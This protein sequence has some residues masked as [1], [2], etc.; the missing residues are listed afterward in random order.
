MTPLIEL[1]NPAGLWWLAVVPL[2]LVPYWLRQRPRRRLVPALFL[3]FGAEPARR[4]RLGGRLRLRPLIVLQ[5][6][7][8]LAVVGALCRPAWRAT[9]VRA[10]L[11]LD[12]SASLRAVDSGQTRFAAAVGAARDEVSRHPATS[13]DL[14]LLSPTPHEVGTNLSASATLARLNELDV[15]ECPHPDES[16]LRS[17]LERL[18]RDRYAGVFVFTD[19]LGSSNPG[20]S[21][22]TVGSPQPNLAIT[23]LTVVPAPVASS[24]ASLNVVVD[25]LSPRPAS[26]PIRVLGERGEQLR[27]GTLEVGAHGSAAF[28]TEAPAAGVLTAHIDGKDALAFDDE[29]SIRMGL[30]G[31]RSLLLVANDAGGLDALQKLLGF[32]LEV[33]PPA[34]YRPELARGRDLVI[35]HLSA[36]SEPAM[37]SAL[38]LLP[39]PTPF[40]PGAV[41]KADAPS[42]AFPLQTHPIARYLNPAALRP[43][44]LLTLAGLP[45]W[46]PLAVADG[47]PVILEHLGSPRAIVS[48]MDLLPYLG[49]RNRPVSILTLNVLSWLLRGAADGGRGSERQCVPIGRAESDLEHPRS[50]PLS[51]NGS[52]AAELRERLHPLWSALT[53]AAL[54]LL[55]LEAWFHRG[56][57]RV[58]WA[59]RALTAALII[60]AWLDPMR[61]IAGVAPPPLALLDVSKSLLEETRTRAIASLGL[62]PTAPILAFAGRPVATTVDRLASAVAKAEV[63]ATDLEAA[64]LNAVDDAPQGGAILLVSDGWETHGDA[65]KA[66]EAIQKRGLRVFPIAAAQSLGN[67]VA[68]TSLSLPAQSASGSAARAEVL[69]R[70]DNRDAVRARITVRQ[71]SK[72]LVREVTRIPPGDSAFGRT[73]LLGGEGLSEF[74]A[75]LQPLDPATDA[76]RSNDVAKA[77]VAIGGGKRVLLLGH[78]RRDNREL[79]HTL[80]A[81]G[82]RVTSVGRADGEAAPEPSRFAAVVLNDLPLSDLPPG[83]ADQLRES[84]RGGG[85][86]AMV[87][88]PRSFGLGGYRGSAVEEALPVRMKERQREEPGNV[89]ALVIDKS[90]SMREESRILYAREAARQLVDHLKDHDRI[91]VIGFDRE[92]F[93]IVPLAEVGEIR[94]EFDERIDRL[95]PSGG[96][97]L[98]PALVEARRQL[99]G[100]EA[101][102]RHVIVLSDGLSE[103]AQSSAQRRQYYD[104]ALALAEQGVTIST[105]ALGREADA[106]FLEHLASFGRGVFHETAEASSLP[107]LVLGEFET[108]GREKTLA[109]REFRPLPAPDSPLVGDLA[110]AE[111]R[112]PLVLGLVETELKPQARLDV[113]VSGSDAPLIASWEFGRGRAVAVTTDA[114]GRWSDRWVRWEQWSRLWTD[115]LRWLVPESRVPQPRF[116][117][118]YRD[119]ALGVDYS[120]FEEG[121]A[122]SVVARITGPEGQTS[123]VPLTRTAPGHFHGRLA[124]LVAGNYRIEIRGPHG[125]I[126][127]PPLGYTIPTSASGERARREPNWPLLETL[128][129]RTGGRL[130]PRVRDVSTAPVPSRAEPLAPLLLGAAALVFLAELIARRLRDD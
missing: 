115:V 123:E 95:K 83:Y 88:G 54:A 24:A 35:F 68:I 33:V 67:D 104:L 109:E 101:R 63:G 41:T 114:N 107:E 10:A 119:G 43:R 60:G 48:G 86:L 36:P 7:L 78:E 92:A 126:T 55:A 22:T 108:Q 61:A 11:V 64:L 110:R 77:W 73:V 52:V 74:T 62:S 99:V 112:W 79:E 85:A 16:Q 40:L 5:L 111:P 82:F 80:S 26:V 12:N 97:R 124:T 53:L 42:I 28:A 3:F 91:T 2:L 69:L 75:E 56:R 89:V 58:A 47:G 17:L 34:Q 90:G 59:L 9:E 70:S 46:Q 125:A 39:P 102:R 49:E 98:F 81:R 29:A 66:L 50:L 106:G 51:S 38:Y 116:A 57:A 113:G 122:G 14:F 19:L 121:S 84:A 8:L 32:R 93:T 103:D 127:D 25:N 15:G 27:S 44:R 87:G 1:A 20:I 117:V 100:Q 45:G 76:D 130:N 71:G 105:I 129:A 31:E 118:A 65:T 18:E 128:A 13:W 6:L 4:L 72:V 96:T 21:V 37:S 120:R 30:G 23:D 94:A